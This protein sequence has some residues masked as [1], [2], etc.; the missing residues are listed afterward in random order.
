V[1]ETFSFL[2]DDPCKHNILL[3]QPLPLPFSAGGFFRLDTLWLL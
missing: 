3:D 2:R 1:L